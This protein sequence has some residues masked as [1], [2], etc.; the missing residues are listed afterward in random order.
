V[1][2]LHF[3]ASLAARNPCDWVLANEMQEEVVVFPV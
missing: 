2:G 3:P 1:A